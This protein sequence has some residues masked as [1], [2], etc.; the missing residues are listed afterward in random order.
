MRSAETFAEVEATSTYLFADC[1]SCFET[2]KCQPRKCWCFQRSFCTVASDQLA[3]AV[4]VAVAD[5][6]VETF[7]DSRHGSERQSS[8]QKGSLQSIE[9]L[10]R[11][12]HSGHE[13][14]AVGQQH[15]RWPTKI[16]WRYSW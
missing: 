15:V 9:G 4:A 2:L 5:A 1:R 6:L 3:I 8:P 13:M 16:I 10:K 7:G 12:R 11:R 14:A